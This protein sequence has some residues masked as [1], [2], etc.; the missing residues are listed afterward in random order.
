MKIR[1]IA[2]ALISAVLT[3]TPLSAHAAAIDLQKLVDDGNAA[4]RVKNYVKPKG[5][6]SSEFEQAAKL[7]G[8][9][10]IHPTCLNG[11]GLVSDAEGKGAQAAVFYDR[12]LTAKE[13]L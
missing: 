3:L 4:Y 1:F 5:F 2:N 6:F 12:A 8:K 13:S 10:S 7:P 9:R 11:L